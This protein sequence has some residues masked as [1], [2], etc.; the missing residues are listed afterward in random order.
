ML[1][2]HASC[3][4]AFLVVVLCACAGSA[5][6]LT[7]TVE[8]TGGTIEGVQENG[9]FSYKG[10]PFAQPPV[11]DLRWKEPQPVEPWTDV[12]KADAFGPACM[13][14]ANSMGN[15]APVSEDCLYINVWTPAQKTDEKLPVIF[16]IYGGG[17]SGGST[18]IP[19]Y[20]G[21]GF[22][23]K[24]VVLVS[25]A[26]R[27]GPFGFLAHPELSSE[28]GRG[29]GTYGLADMIAGLEWVQENIGLFGGDPSNVTIFGHSAGGM[30]VNILSASPVAKGLFSR[31]ICMSGGSMAPLQTSNQGG[32]GLG[33]PTLELAEA[34]GREFLEK[35]GAADLK[36]ARALKAEEIQ[37]ALG[38]GMGGGGPRFRPVA[39]GYIVPSDLYSIYQAGNFNDTPILL[40]NT[41]AELGGFGG[42]RTVTPEAFERQIRAQYGPHADAILSV[43]PHATDDEA[44]KASTDISRESTFSWS[45]WTWA[46]LQTEKGQGGAYLYYYDHHA[47]DAAGSG[48][49]SDVPYAFQT[50]SPGPQGEPNPEDLKLSDMIS[51]YWVNFARTGDPNGPG[52]P[53]WPAF[54]EDDQK[55][56]VFEELPGAQ[57]VPNLDKLKAYDGYVEWLRTTED[58]SAASE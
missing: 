16:W 48:H 32:M 8:V 12:K 4:V 9:I 20:D 5:P 41:S 55:A 33:I 36:S 19:M 51:S 23:R 7:T 29:S 50:L 1:F 57:P 11:G 30:A 49:G 45:T 58:S 44:A 28:S 35:L 52:L 38:G 18:S 10:I 25:G 24:G 27:V 56:M 46:R 34:S 17:F 43:Y 54:A 3:C 14:T 21:T 39:D 26:Y 47:P 31:A 22:A 42:R 15:S 53:E 2:K 37:G 13:Q 40:G 6:P